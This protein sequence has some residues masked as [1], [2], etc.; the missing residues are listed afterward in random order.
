MVSEASVHGRLLHGRSIVEG[1][2]EQ[3]HSLHGRW[4]ME[5]GRVPQRERPG[6]RGST[7]GHTPATHPDTLMCALLSPRSSRANE[8]SSLV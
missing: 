8:I 5:H 2:V 3:S 6:A 1:V 4:E 7:Q